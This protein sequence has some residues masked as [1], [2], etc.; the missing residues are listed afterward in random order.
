MT[1][2]GIPGPID[3]RVDLTDWTQIQGMP[4]PRTPEPS[5]T[6]GSLSSRTG[7]ALTTRGAAPSRERG[8]VLVQDLTVTKN[9]DKATPK[10][11][12]FSSSGRR[13]REA[14]LEI[15]PVGGSPGERTVIKMKNAV[16]TRI[17]EQPAIRGDDPTEAVT[18]S[19][20]SIEWETQAASTPRGASPIPYTLTPKPR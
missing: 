15:R 12:L 1:I 19:C 13:L 16:I 6:D 3:I 20:Q 10:I 8:S 2:D 4:D 17:A 7:S 18:F 14:T 11:G 5:G 9:I